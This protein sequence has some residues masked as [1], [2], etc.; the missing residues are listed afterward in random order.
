MKESDVVVGRLVP[1][2]QNAPKAVHPTVSPFCH[3]VLGFD[4]GSIFDGPGVFTPAP[5]V[6]SQAKLLQGRRTSAKS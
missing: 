4:T 1:A 3:L 2:N 5:G 6:G